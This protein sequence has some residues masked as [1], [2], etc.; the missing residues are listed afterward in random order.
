MASGIPPNQL[1]RIFDRF[2]QVEGSA[3]RRYEGTGHRI[4]LVKAGGKRVRTKAAMVESEAGRGSTF[5]YYASP[6]KCQRRH[7]RDARRE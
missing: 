2:T 4:G 1:E 5:H 7:Y 6:W 3:T